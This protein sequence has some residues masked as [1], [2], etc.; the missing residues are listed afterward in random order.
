M[1]AEDNDPGY[2]IVKVYQLASIKLEACGKEFPFSQTLLCYML[3]GGPTSQAQDNMW[4][5]FLA[6]V[7]NA[8]L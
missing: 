1:K 2:T 3:Y 5:D 7:K 6:C 4:E 8:Y